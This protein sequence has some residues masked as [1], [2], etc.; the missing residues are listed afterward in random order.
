MERRQRFGSVLNLPHAHS[1]SGKMVQSLAPGWPMA[2]TRAL[3]REEGCGTN[4]E[5]VG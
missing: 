2:I 4:S 5:V 1:D 3:W